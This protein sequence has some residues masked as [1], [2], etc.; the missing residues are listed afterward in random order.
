MRESFIFYRSFFEAAETLKSK[1]KL[2]LF[3]TICDYA[4]NGA[5]PDLEGA[6]A[7]MFKLLKP[8]IDANNR[9]FEN[10][11]KGGRPKKNQTETKTKPNNNQTETK[12]KRNNNDNVNVN[13]NDNVNVNVNDNNNNNDNGVGCGGGS[14]D[15]VFNIWKRLTPQDVDKIY[16]V[17]PESGGFLIET[18][19][20]EVKRN[21]RDVRDPVPYILTYAKNVGWDD[22]AEHGG[23]S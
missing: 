6:P 10:G 2:K 15:D 17:Y 12:A 14:G 3:E 23:V 5:E 9:R 1:D 22:N 7:G 21:Q 20:E 18:V 19:Y 11:S 13:V 8:Q 4:L 16:N